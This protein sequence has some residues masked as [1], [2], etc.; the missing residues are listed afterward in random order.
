MYPKSAIDN[1]FKTYI[2]NESIV[3]SGKDFGKWEALHYS[4]PYIWSFSHVTKKDED[5]FVNTLVLTLTFCHQNLV[6]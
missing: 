2:E 4:L 6:V 3:D 1:Q 5:V